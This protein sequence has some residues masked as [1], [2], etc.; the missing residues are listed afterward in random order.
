M[1]VAHAI[2]VFLFLFAI[3]FVFGK[4]DHNINENNTSASCNSTVVNGTDLP[5]LDYKSFTINE[6]N[7]QLC[8]DACC[9]DPK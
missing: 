4:S 7:Y 5:G 1:K 8:I 9:A 6:S 2:C 3:S